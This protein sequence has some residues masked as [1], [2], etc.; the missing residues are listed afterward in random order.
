MTFR[1]VVAGETVIKEGDPGDEM[2]IID[3]GTFNVFK[4]DESGEEI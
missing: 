2:Y 3:N 1:K 4:R